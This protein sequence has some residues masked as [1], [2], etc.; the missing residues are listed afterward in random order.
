MTPHEQQVLALQ[1][2]MLQASQQGEELKAVMEA[3]A[4]DMESHRFACTRGKVT[5]TINGLGTLV[6]LQILGDP[7][8]QDLVRAA[9]SVAYH[10]AKAYAEANMGLGMSN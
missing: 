3:K 10:Q 2:A 7:D 4:R 8:T 6:D 9:W 1:T 5:V